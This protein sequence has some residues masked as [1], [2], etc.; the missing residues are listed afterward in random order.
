MSQNP[1]QWVQWIGLTLGTVIAFG[2]LVRSAVNGLMARH[3][4][5]RSAASSRVWPSPR[6]RR[7]C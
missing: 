6:A 1:D 5:S 3:D 2:S 7:W 4:A